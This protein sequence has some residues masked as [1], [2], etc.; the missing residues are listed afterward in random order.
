[1]A[2]EEEISSKQQCT[3]DM[4]TL[5]IKESASLKTQTEMMTEQLQESR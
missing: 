3:Q 4:S 5:Q 1:M 2:I